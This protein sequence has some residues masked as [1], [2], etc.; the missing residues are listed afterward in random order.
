MPANSAFTPR[1]I[2][3]TEKSL[4]AILDRH[5]A[6]AKLTEQHWITLTLV[7]ASGG[8]IDRGE[9][10]ERVSAGAK[11]GEDD[12][13]ARV[14]ELVE[15]QQLLDDS[16]SPKVTLTDTGK[17]LHARIRSANVE[18]TQRLWGDLPAAD[19]EVAARVL[20]TIL[21]RANAELRSP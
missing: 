7:V 6:G 21:E 13:R 1:L 20:A 3:E 5:L 17:E 9:L 10:V 19:L 8:A 14:T 18:L 4:N 2:G 15:R 11:F 12:V 16:D